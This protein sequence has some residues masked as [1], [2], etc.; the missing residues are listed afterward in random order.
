[1]R[2]A[3]AALSR[4]NN[5]H[6]DTSRTAEFN[7]MLITTRTPLR[8]SFFGG[9]TDLPGYYRQSSHG[10]VLSSAI[11]QYVYVTVKSHGPL[12]DENFRLNYSKTEIVDGLDGID[13]GIARE[14][15]RMLKLLPPLYIST[16][17]DVPSGSGLGSS[18]AYAVGLLH[19][20][21]SLQKQR[22]TAGELA[23]M[24]CYVE[25][26]ALAKPIGKQDQYAAAFGGMNHIRFYPD[27]TTSITPVNHRRRQLDH[28]FDHLMLFWTGMS[29][30]ADDVLTAQR[31]A[32]P[33]TTG[34][35]DEMRAMA[36]EA[37]RVIES[38]ELGIEAFGRLLD[39]AWALKRSLTGAISTSR[40]DSW[41]EAARKAGAFGGK[42]CGAG[43]GGFLLF[44]VPLDGRAAVREALN[45]LREVEIGFEPSGTAVLYS[46][47]H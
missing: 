24:A 15:I 25:I 28:L 22:K 2:G 47:A 9:G 13:N 29:R 17:A 8:I 11:D 41:Y 26:D 34:Y 27:E 35:L 43:G 3:G 46:A 5:Q 37:A 30:N 23:E 1:M 14:G 39:T 21:T 40:I 4:G 18:S 16:V 6:D 42:L 31:A 36:D 33:S 7:A 38:G 20:L 32:I 45:E 10:A 12:F 19:A 44:C